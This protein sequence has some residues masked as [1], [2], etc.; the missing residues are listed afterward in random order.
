[1]QTCIRLIKEYDGLFQTFLKPNARQRVLNGWCE[2]HRFY[3][4]EY[5]LQGVIDE[6][7][8]DP[9]FRLLLDIE[10]AALLI[11]AFYHDVYYKVGDKENEEKSCEALREDW[12]YHDEGM[13]N[14]IC[15]IIMATKYRKRPLPQKQMLENIMWS[16]DN[17]GFS[18]GLNVLKRNEELLQKEFIPVFGKKLYKKGQIDFLKTN[19][20]LFSK[21]VDEDL[22]NLIK[23][24]E[25]TL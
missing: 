3:H 21:K 9:R 13:L 8:K 7:V 5:H 18:K 1:M 15:D 12:D 10:R 6:I 24:I 17:A 22:K 20:G 23:H 19:F 2:R 11:G 4:D 16:A 25:D 14:K